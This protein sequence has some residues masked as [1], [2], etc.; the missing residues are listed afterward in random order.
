MLAP[1]IT[2]FDGWGSDHNDHVGAENNQPEDASTATNSHQT[3]G[4]RHGRDLR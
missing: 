1:E 4:S 3:A 2:D